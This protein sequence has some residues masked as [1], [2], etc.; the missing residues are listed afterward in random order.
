M[1]LELFLLFIC[2]IVLSH[3]VR[4]VGFNPPKLKEKLN[5]YTR[6]CLVQSFMQHFVAKKFETCMPD[7]TIKAPTYSV[8]A[9]IF[10]F[11]NIYHMSLLFFE[12]L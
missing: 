11:G 1:G 12:M 10:C 6:A 4:R 8:G 7:S 5:S 2:Y 3:P 9:F